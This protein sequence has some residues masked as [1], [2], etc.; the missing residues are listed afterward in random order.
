[1]EEEK[2]SGYCNGECLINDLPN[3]LCTLHCDGSKE[4]YCY[5]EEK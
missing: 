1:M 5:R 2:C 4:N 3:S